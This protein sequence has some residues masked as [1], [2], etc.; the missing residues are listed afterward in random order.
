M[1]LKGHHNRRYIPHRDG[2]GA[3]Q[4][5]TFHL[6]D[7]VPKKVIETWKSKLHKEL[8][9]SDYTIK[10]KADQKLLNLIA[11]YEDSGKGCCLLEDLVNATIIQ[12]KLLQGH[13]EGYMLIACCIMPNHVHVLIRQNDGNSHSAIVQNWKGRTARLVNQANNSSGVLWAKD[14][15][16]RAIRDGDHFLNTLS[17]INRNPVKANLVQEPND[18]LYSSV[19]Q[20]WPKPDELFNPRSSD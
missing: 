8:Y 3:L 20:N 4:S 11:K 12:D 5:I 19:G 15:F 10:M 7:S 13:S 9:S 1:N 14:Y 2:G 18:W 6:A 16:D 17:Y